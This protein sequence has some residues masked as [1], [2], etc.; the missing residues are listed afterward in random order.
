MAWASP[1]L[2]GSQC[3]HSP[4]QAWQA[5]EGWGGGG[6]VFQHHQPRQ[7]CGVLQ[8]TSD[9]VQ[10]T[11][12]VYGECAETRPFVGRRPTR[13]HTHSGNVECPV[14]WTHPV[15]CTEQEQLLHD[16]TTRRLDDS[17]ILQEVQSQQ[18]QCTE[19]AEE[20]PQGL[21]VRCARIIKDDASSSGSCLT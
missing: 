2:T 6:G 15:L 18:E 16:W 12:L 1:W 17:K 4:W 7:G 3:R 14:D 8:G 9:S 5:W 20:M 10:I 11:F 19:A 13:P 21:Q